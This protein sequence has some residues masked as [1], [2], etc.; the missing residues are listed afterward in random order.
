MPQQQQT[1]LG[2]VFSIRNLVYTIFTLFQYGTQLGGQQGD[3]PFN[4]PSS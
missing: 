3:Q 2:L 1:N 4:L